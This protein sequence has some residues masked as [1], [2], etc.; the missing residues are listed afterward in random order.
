MA[1]EGENW[2]RSLSGINVVLALL[3][4]PAWDVGVD[5]LVAQSIEVVDSAS[6]NF[7]GGKRLLGRC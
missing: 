6:G 2:N 7:V 1:T 5:I 4:A 3:V